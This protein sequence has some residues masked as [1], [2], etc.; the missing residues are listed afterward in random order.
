[1]SLP[2]PVRSDTDLCA[3]I[4]RG[5]ERAF[6]ELYETYYVALRRYATSLLGNRDAGEDIVQGLF[7]RLW[8]ERESWVVR[9][10]LR[11]Y[12]YRAVHTRV[13]SHW[14]A[15]K[16]RRRHAEYEVATM[17]PGGASAPESWPDHAM[18]QTELATAYAREV[19]ALAPRA[20]EAFELHCQHGLSC[21]ET[22]DVMGISHRT[23]ENHVGRALLALRKAL[24]P[25]LSVV[26]ILSLR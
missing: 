22:A 8:T 7:A 25:Y 18:H 17:A 21:R 12:L 1:M 6:R 16:V 24:G 9:G 26:L 14:R 2:H 15:L 3:R 11:S 5:D 23:V 19:A 10:N 13:V 4:R 20:R